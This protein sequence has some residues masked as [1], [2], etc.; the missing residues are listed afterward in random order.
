MGSAELTDL[1]A[2]KANKKL[3]QSELLVEESN[4]NTAQNKLKLLINNK[5]AA[6][7]VHILPV[8]TIDISPKDVLLVPNLKTAFDN[9]RDY[10][11][12]RDDIEAKDIELMMKKNEQWPQLDLEGSFKMNGIRRSLL[13]S[14]QDTLDETNTEY[15]AGLTFSFPLEG[16]E[17]KSAYE[18]AKGEKAK[19]LVS[20]KKIEKTIVS[21]IDNKVRTVNAYRQRAN[22]FFEVAELQ[23]QKLQEEEKKYRYGR[24]DSDRIIRFQEDYLNSE[25]AKGQ[26]ILDYM[27][28]LVELYLSQ[29]TYLAKRGLTVE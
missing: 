3:R 12:A 27:E 6:S 28:A 10:K 24:S 14:I 4:L 25:I 16:R 23:K 20:L 2:A 1:Y 26:A 7:S 17:A 21:E 13:G 19:S 15:Y 22:E 8:D 29:N 11:R 5:E 9:R 18:K